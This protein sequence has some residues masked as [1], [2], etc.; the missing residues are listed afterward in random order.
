[1]GLAPFVSGVKQGIDAVIQRFLFYRS[2]IVILE[3]LDKEADHI[4]GMFCKQGRKIIIL[5]CIVN[6]FCNALKRLQGGQVKFNIRITHAFDA[7]AVDVVCATLFD[8]CFDPVCQF[9]VCCFL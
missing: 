6:D 4:T 9:T 8:L 2:H 7:E 3:C 1:M 5:F